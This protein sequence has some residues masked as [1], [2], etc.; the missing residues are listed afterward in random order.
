MERLKPEIEN[1]RHAIR[2]EQKAESRRKG[3]LNGF[4]VLARLQEPET[5]LQAL[6][7]RVA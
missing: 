1:E 3:G 5:G 7:Y 2:P 6:K 4:W